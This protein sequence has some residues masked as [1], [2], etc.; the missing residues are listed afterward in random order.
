MATLQRQSYDFEPLSTLQLDPATAR[1]TSTVAQA[2]VE[3]LGNTL[4]AD[5]GES[6]EDYYDLCV[7]EVDKILILDYIAVS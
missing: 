7:A 2:V 5:N 3:V 1:M 6:L 4:V